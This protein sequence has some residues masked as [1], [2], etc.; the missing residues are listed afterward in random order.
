[1]YLKNL[2]FK[3]VKSWEL[4]LQRLCYIRGTTVI[5]H[6]LK[7]CVK[8]EGEAESG[9]KSPNLNEVLMDEV[10]KIHVIGLALWSIFYNYQFYENNLGKIKAF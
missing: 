5:N 1:M 9:Q 6:S 7:L 3:V 4:I 10:G 2:E 8:P